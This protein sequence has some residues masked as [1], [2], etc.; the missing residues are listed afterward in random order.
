MHALATPLHLVVVREGEGVVFQDKP[1]THISQL[2][3]FAPKDDEGDCC[4]YHFYNHNPHQPLQ[5]TTYY[6]YHELQQQQHQPQQQQM[7]MT[8]TTTAS[9]G[10]MQTGALGGLLLPLGRKAAA[11]AVVVPPGAVPAVVA[12]G[13]IRHVNKPLVALDFVQKE[14]PTAKLWFVV[15]EYIL[16]K[17][18]GADNTGDTHNFALKLLNMGGFVHNDVTLMRVAKELF[19]YEMMQYSRPG[20]RGGNNNNNAKNSGGI[21]PFFMPAAAVKPVEAASAMARLAQY[22]EDIARPA[23]ASGVGGGGGMTAAMKGMWGLLHRSF[24]AGD[25]AALQKTGDFIVNSPW[26]F[27]NTSLNELSKAQMKDVVKDT[28]DR[29]VKV[30]DDKGLSKSALNA[31]VNNIR[32]EFYTHISNIFSKWYEWAIRSVGILRQAALVTFSKAAEGALS[33]A[34]NT[35]SASVAELGGGRGRGG[36]NKKKEKPPPSETS[37][38]S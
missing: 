27:D 19:A 4:H 21:L 15:G 28:V 12:A 3:S 37:D 1:R 13:E 26:G 8:T 31:E 29:L 9:T 38:K 14:I 6:G 2:M 22:A 34:E 17:Y 25:K 24:V 10:R 30:L 33:D 16:G 18:Y 7:M 20:A 36:A 23:N 5:T 32:K 35:L 11:A